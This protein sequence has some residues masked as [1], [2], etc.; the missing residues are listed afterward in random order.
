MIASLRRMF[1][2][3]SYVAR[4][5]IARD[6][7]GREAAPLL[8]AGAAGCTSGYVQDIAAGVGTAEGARL[9]RGPRRGGHPSTPFLVIGVDGGEGLPPRVYPRRAGATAIV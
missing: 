7:D 3:Q 1:E 8:A 4:R 9:V 6:P 2:A 5:S